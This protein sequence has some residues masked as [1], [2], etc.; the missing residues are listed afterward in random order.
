MAQQQWMR[1]FA[2]WH[3][4]LGWLVG[5]PIVM[6]MATGLF[7]VSRP[8]EEVRG[9][10][11]RKEMP[12][13]ALPSDTN[14]AVTLP[15]EGAKPVR[16]VITTMV[17][18]RPVTSFTYMDGSVERF[19]ADGSRI[20]PVGEIAARMIVAQQIEG[21][22][23]IVSATPFDADKV[24]FDFRREEPVWQIVL[25]NGAHIYVNRETGEIA[26]VRT[27]WWRIFD[28]MW[29]LHIMDLQT[30]EDSSHPILILFATLGL[31]GSVLGCI[32]MFRRRRN[33]VRASDYAA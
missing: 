15:Q 25:D 33:R 27:R 30:R 8:I 31:I 7:M 24:P 12:E 22:D 19:A 4:W 17:G 6:W 9:N 5:V 14:I 16:S 29:G 11:L 1:N 3:I 23:T 10:H 21:G 28:F 2:R 13:Q 20:K 32:L 26:A 18:G